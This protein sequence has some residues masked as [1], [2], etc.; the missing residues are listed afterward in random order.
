MMID[1]ADEPSGSA[2]LYFILSAVPETAAMSTGASSALWA[3]LFTK[4]SN[5]I[6]L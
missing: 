1:D 3:T 4:R 2:P 6:Y 5:A